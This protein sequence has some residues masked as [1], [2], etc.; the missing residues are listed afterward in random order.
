MPIA[1]KT[2]SG[3]FRCQ[4][5][6]REDGKVK[7]K[8]FTADTK[9]EAEKLAFAF[10]SRKKITDEKTIAKALNDY[11]ELKKPVLSPSTIRGYRGIETI[12]LKDYP[13]FMK[14]R[15]SMVF[16]T[17]MQ[18]TISDIAQTKSPKT[19]KN[20]KSLLC[21]IS[22]LF[23]D[24]S[25]TL[26]QSIKYDVTIPSDAEIR[27]FLEAEKGK[28]LEVPIML[29]ALCMMRAGEITSLSIDDCNFK[30]NTIHIRH[31]KVQDEDGEWI[32]KAPKTTSSDRFIKIPKFV[33]NTIK[34]KGYITSYNTKS[35][36][37]NFSRHRERLGLSKF[38]FHDLRHYACST[39]ME[40]CGLAYTQKYG[41]WSNPQTPLNIYN[42]SK[43]DKE[44]EHSKHIES[45]FE[46]NF[47][48]YI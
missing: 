45:V 44:D 37:R 42:H 46:N 9:K 1:K 16:E 29:A 6:Y 40:E 33:M 28:E 30:T 25:I 47:N 48:T 26:P 3:K 14:K 22:P 34:K 24:F 32:V 7:N 39:F 11:I 5:A 27:T 41:G 21:S 18:K 4:V 36:Q 15:C 13:D 31:S 38:R 12:L 2:K 8:Q 35:L 10:I 23:K 43:K 19:T 17:D 20:Y